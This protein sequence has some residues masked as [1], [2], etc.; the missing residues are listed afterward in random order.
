LTKK[1]KIYSKKKKTI[2]MNLQEETVGER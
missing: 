2:Q 1:T